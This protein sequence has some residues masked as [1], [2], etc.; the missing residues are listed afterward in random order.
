MCNTA[1]PGGAD[2]PLSGHL[3]E[4]RK[5]IL[6]V[7]IPMLAVLPLALWLAP[8]F[9]GALFRPLSLLRCTVYKYGVLDG[10]TLLIRSALL[11]ELVA[12]SPLILWELARFLWPGLYARERR[13]VLVSA[14]AAGMLFI[15]GVI[16][17]FRFAVGPLTELWFHRAQV[18]AP[19]LS[20]TSCYDLQLICLLV[21]GLAAASPAALF[22][23]IWFRKVHQK[24]ENP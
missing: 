6:T 24:E 23:W 4:L 10:L 3:E 8:A 16:V 17:Y 13:G 7:V 18:F 20:A 1:I 22:A 12:F 5:R 2:M 15:L 14:F 21:C 11:M 19:Q 9:L